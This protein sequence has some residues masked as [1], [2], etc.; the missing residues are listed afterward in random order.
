M[1]RPEE[2]Q[3]HDEDGHH[4]EGSQLKQVVDQL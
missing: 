3:S 1:R 2:F 4:S